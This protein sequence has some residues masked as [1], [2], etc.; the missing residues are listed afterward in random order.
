MHCHRGP[1]INRFFF[2]QKHKQFFA[3]NEGMFVMLRRNAGRKNVRVRFVTEVKDFY[4][5]PDNNTKKL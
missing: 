2:L 5:L 3:P 1:H 4:M